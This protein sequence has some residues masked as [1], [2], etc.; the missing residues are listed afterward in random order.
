M[1]TKTTRE[2][3]TDDLFAGGPG[4]EETVFEVW[5]DPVE[6]DNSNGRLAFMAKELKTGNVIEHQAQPEWTWHIR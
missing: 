4:P 6:T 2:L 1:A 5:T 3:K